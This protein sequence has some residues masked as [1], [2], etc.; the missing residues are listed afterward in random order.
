MTEQRRKLSVEVPPVMRKESLPM[1]MVRETRRL[2]LSI[3][4]AKMGRYKPLLR[5]RCSQPVVNNIIRSFTAFRAHSVTSET[6]LTLP[7]LDVLNVS[8]RCVLTLLHDTLF[9][10]SQNRNSVHK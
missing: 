2:S 9:V 10:P 6:T 3:L 8:S 1:P 5:R 4:G 7:R